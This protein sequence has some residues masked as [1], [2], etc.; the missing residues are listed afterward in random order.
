MSAKYQP[1]EGKFS[2]LC[3]STGESESGGQTDKRPPYGP[4]APQGDVDSRVRGNDVLDHLQTR[5]T[6]CYATMA[7]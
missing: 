5:V 2:P 7:S 6:T 4:P 1:A 3:V